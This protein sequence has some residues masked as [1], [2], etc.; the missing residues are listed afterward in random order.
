M[1]GQ[2]TDL[3]LVQALILSQLFPAWRQPK[4]ALLSW[5]ISGRAMKLA[6]RRQLN[7][8]PA[9]LGIHDGPTARARIKTWWC[10]YIVDIWDAARRGRPPSLHETDANVPLPELENDTDEEY[11]F[12]RLV[13]LTRILANVLSFAF[14]NCK[15]SATLQ[16]PDSTTEEA[17]QT[18]RTQLHDWF[19]APRLLPQ[20][21]HSNLQVAYLTICIL[22]HRPLLPTPLA[23]AF[24]DPVVLLL[25]K[26]ASDIVR[27]A[28]MNGTMDAGSVIWRLFVPAVGY[29]T[30]G[31]TLAQNAAWSPQVQGAQ[32]LRQAAQRDINRLLDFF[33]KAESQGH[34]ATGMSAVLR[35]IFQRSGVEITV[36]PNAPL[37][38]IEMGVP[39]PHE[40]P[41]FSIVQLRAP[42]AKAL[43]ERHSS[44]QMLQLVG[45][46]LPSSDSSMLK[47]KFDAIASSSH[48]GSVRGPPQPL[49][50][51]AN[52]TG[53]D[54][55]RRS[56]TA[57]S[58]HSQSTYS[59]HSSTSQG[60]HGQLYP[61]S[62]APA[63]MPVS[64]AYHPLYGPAMEGRQGSRGWEQKGLMSPPPSLPPM[65]ER[66]YQGPPPTKFP[67]GRGEFNPP[68][69]QHGYDRRDSEYY[70][71]PISPTTR[72]SAS[73]PY[74][75]TTQQSGSSTSFHGG[76]HPATPSI[77]PRYRGPTPPSSV[78][79]AGATWPSGHP[80]ASPQSASSYRYDYPAPSSAGPSPRVSAGSGQV[81][82]NEYYYYPPPR[83]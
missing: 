70:Q 66:R 12:L 40:D 11:F 37:P 42:P 22:L 33:D 15:S 61:Y 30:A 47:R 76:Q 46:G 71:R 4:V 28:Q 24:A 36:P 58:V 78:N 26:C 38:E 45:P 39:L 19:R 79:S 72:P 55:G 56:P 17:V 74:P 50:S 34:S 64:T 49:P 62:S 20:T 81:R 18:L 14:N 65:Y 82:Y 60:R 83:E 51:L 2:S 10:V 43:S 44:G 7:R 54:A 67:P 35:S 5:T 41:S 21:L 29:L 23:T 57:R 77:D 16:T 63:P 48:S 3:S 73:V 1:T 31:V 32:P 75:I 59:S 25:T 8:S 69:Q 6:L 52:L 9:K 27:L 68:P 80:Y 53:L 13:Q